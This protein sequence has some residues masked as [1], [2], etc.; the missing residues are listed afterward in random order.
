MKWWHHVGKLKPIFIPLTIVTFNLQLSVLIR[1]T[2]LA[3]L[4]SILLSLAYARFVCM[5]C[6]QFG[7]KLVEIE[8]KEE[9]D[10]LKQRISIYDDESLSYHE[11][12]KFWIGGTDRNREGSFFWASTG[13]SLTFTDWDRGEPNDEDSVEDCIEISTFQTRTGTWN[14]NNCALKYHYI[15]EKSC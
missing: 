11:Y 13:S 10:F 15:C 9:N 14:D 3:T 6:K 4:T 12:K 2:S 7:A 8:T 5:E 1:S